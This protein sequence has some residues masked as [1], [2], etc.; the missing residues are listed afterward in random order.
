MTYEL[1]AR[2]RETK[3]YVTLDRFWDI[4]QSY[5]MLDKVDPELYYEA[6][7]IEWDENDFTPHCLMYVDL[8][9]P[10]K[11]RRNKNGRNK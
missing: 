6:M 8:E 1:A 10:K 9:N 5:Y 11:L 7:I 4:N 2:S 3:R